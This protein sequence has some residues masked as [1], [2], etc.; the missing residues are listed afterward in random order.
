MGMYIAWGAIPYRVNTLSYLQF[1]RSSFDHYRALLPQTVRRNT[2]YFMSL[3]F[4]VVVLN[5]LGFGATGAPEDLEYCTF[6][7]GGPRLV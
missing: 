6:G 4:Q 1:S 3:G 2:P 5:M 7:V